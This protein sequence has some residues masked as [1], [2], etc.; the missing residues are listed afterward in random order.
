MGPSQSRRRRGWPLGQSIDQL[1]LPSACMHVHQLLCMGSCAAV[2]V[3]GYLTT[4]L[5][6]GA[7]PAP[8]QADNAAGQ[9]ALLLP[10]NACIDEAEYQDSC[11]EMHLHLQVRLSGAE[12]DYQLH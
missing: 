9:P 11:S 4:L 12:A 2:S 3:S 8:W 7:T 5:C 6:P 10:D 1:A